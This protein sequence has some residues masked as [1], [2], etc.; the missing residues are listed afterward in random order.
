VHRD[1]VELTPEDEGA[2]QER[3]KVAVPERVD[4][5]VLHAHAHVEDVPI[6]AYIAPHEWPMK[7]SG[8]VAPGA[9]LSMTC[10]RS[11][12]RAVQVKSPGSCRCER[13]EPR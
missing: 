9:E 8:W 12:S 11:S 3:R 7:T 4:H 5:R 6:V 13:P 10:L 1:D 2:S